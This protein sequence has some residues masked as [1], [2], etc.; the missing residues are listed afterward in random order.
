MEITTEREMSVFDVIAP[1]VAE[2]E[3]IEAGGEVRPS[4]VAALLRF[5]ADLVVDYATALQEERE[6]NARLVKDCEEMV[7]RLFRLEEHLRGGIVRE[8]MSKLAD[9]AGSVGHEDLDDPPRDP[10]PP[11][12]EP[13]A[14]KRRRK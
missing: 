1:A 13:T 6:S 10:F 4:E 12:P 7:N 5:N 11:A 9:Y 14:G 8:V 2:A 3:R